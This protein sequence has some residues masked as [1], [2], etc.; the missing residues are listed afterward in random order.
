MPFFVSGDLDVSRGDSANAAGDYTSASS[1][2]QAAAQRLFWR[3]DLWEKAGLAA[4]K[5]NEPQNA[6]LFLQKASHLSAQ[7]WLALGQAYTQNKQFDLAIGAYQ[8]ALTKYGASPQA[9][10]GLAQIYY[11]RGELDAERLA[12]QN[13]LLLA[14]QDAAAQY[15][16]GLLLSLT[17]IRSAMTHLQLA[18]Q[19]DPE[20]ASVFQTLRTALDLAELEP[21]ESARL[22]TLGR[23]LGLVNEWTLAEVAFQESVEMDANNAEAWAWLGESKQHLGENGR[24]ELDRALS[25]NPQSVVVRGLRGLYW[26]RL[27]DDRNALA[28]YQA[29]AQIEPD[30]PAWKAS[31]GETYA[32]LGDL[33]SALAA[34]QR[35]TE[36]ASSD[37]TYWR[38]L[39][40]FCA[41][42]SVRVDDVGLPAAQKAVELTPNDPLALDALGWSQLSLGQFSAAI[43]TLLS[44]LKISP[45]LAAAHLHLALAYLQSGDRNA[46][47]DQLVR[48][49]KLDPQG[50][51]GQQAAQ[52]LKQYFSQ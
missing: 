32:R 44:A 20:Y 8:S 17:N 14:P 15:R 2:Y 12:L 50:V 21:S 46:A 1:A 3:D 31:I 26:K 39:A 35:A 22:E 30:N 51:Y 13:Q 45:D 9:Y 42:Y 34:Y 19:L 18:S 27:G 11:Q 16:L 37:A 29:A 28:E 48:V 33:V 38:L 23:G 7:G 41:Q 49:Q 36:I 24:A 10:A 52:I 47:Y 40:T 4:F 5:A 25:I 6:I 43:E